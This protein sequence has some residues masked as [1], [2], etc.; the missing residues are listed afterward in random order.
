MRRLR[1]A[2]VITALSLLASAA[3]ASA[4]CAWVLWWEESRITNREMQQAVDGHREPQ[5][6]MTWRRSFALPTF[7]GCM[8]SLRVQMKVAADANDVVFK[9]PTFIARDLG[10]GPDGVRYTVRMHC[11][12]DTVD[13]REPKSAPR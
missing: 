2:S 9:E 12:P 1:R 4:E 13:P 5:P 8:E 7:E 11:W 3:T 10:R 6:R